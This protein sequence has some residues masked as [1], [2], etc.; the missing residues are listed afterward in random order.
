M[1]F[2]VRR[3][4]TSGIVNCLPEWHDGPAQSL[5]SIGWAAAESTGWFHSV[6]IDVGDSDLQARPS[7]GVF[8]LGGQLP[9]KGDNKP[10]E[11]VVID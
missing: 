5:C 9:L 3:V 4:T 7:V 10:T 6:C 8:P 2:T 11:T 1:P